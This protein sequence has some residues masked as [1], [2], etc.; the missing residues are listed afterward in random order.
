MAIKACLEDNSFTSIRDVGS[1][2]VCSLL[3]LNSRLKQSSRYISTYSKNLPHLI[4]VYFVVIHIN[5]L[6]SLFC[7]IA[8]TKIKIED[9]RGAYPSI[10]LHFDDDST[11][12]LVLERYVPNEASR[13]NKDFE[14]SCNFIG[15]LKNDRKA[16]SAVTGS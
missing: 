5:N 14:K 15:H 2:T 7:I 10:T 6:I 1:Y 3:S 13:M 9:T 8:L 16:C 4:H 11:D 12:Q